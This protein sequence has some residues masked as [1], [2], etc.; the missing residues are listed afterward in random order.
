MRLSEKMKRRVP[1]SRRGVPSR[2]GT[3]SYPMPD[4]EHAASAKGFAAM[5]HG[6]NSSV[7]RQVAAK[8]RKLGYGEGPAS[9]DT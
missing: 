4:A 5:H 7:Y 1:R 3:G 9:E 2:S 6:K 8:A